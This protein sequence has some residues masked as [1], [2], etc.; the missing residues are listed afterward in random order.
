MVKL[1]ENRRSLQTSDAGVVRRATAE[2]A[3]VRNARRNVRK[4]WPLLEF[5]SAQISRC[6]RKEEARQLQRGA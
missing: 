2:V 6:E 3:V 5:T 1:E 4:R